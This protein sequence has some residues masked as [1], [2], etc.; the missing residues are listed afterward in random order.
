MDQ[1]VLMPWWLVLVTDVLTTFI[2]TAGG[3][4]QAVMVATNAPIN[5]EAWISAGLAGF[6]MSAIQLR[7]RMS[8]PP[9]R[10]NGDGD[11]KIEPVVKP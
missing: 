3:A 2:I 8:L 4:I 5:V 6:V 9:I 1:H 7:A 11:V 10:K